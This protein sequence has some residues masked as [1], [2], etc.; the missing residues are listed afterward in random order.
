MDFYV[1]NS[2]VTFFTVGI[3]TVLFLAFFKRGL[4]EKF[5][6]L[7]TLGWAFTLLHYLSQVVAVL[8]PEQIN[9][10]FFLDRL[11]LSYSV[12]VFFLSAREFLGK[13]KSWSL[14][15]GL[16]GLFTLFS[17]LQ[18]YKPSDDPKNLLGPNWKATVWNVFQ[19]LNAERLSVLLGVVLLATGLLFFIHRKK[20]GS[21]GVTAMAYAF[22]VWGMAFL[23]F[24][25][26][27]RFDYIVPLVA[28]LINLPKP[29]VA[30][31][32]IIYL[33]ERE[34]GV[35]Q[36]HRDEAVQ[37]RDFIQSLMDSAYDSIY[38][39]DREGKFRW[40]NKAC[41]RLLGISSGELKTRRYSEFLE[42]EEHQRVSQAGRTVAS[43]NKASMEINVIT[44]GGRRRSMQIMMSPI[45][46]AQNLVSSVLTVGRDV[47]EVNAMERQLR[48]AEKLVALG[49][50]IAGVAH[51]LN[52]PLTTM[53]GFSELSLQEK[54]LDPRLRQRFEMILQAATRSKKI[55]ESLQ[56][57]VRVPEHHVEPVEIN[58]L[59][60]DNL[61]TMESELL[62]RKIALRL[63]YAPDPMWVD[64]DRGRVGQVIQSIV[65]N[66]VE[67]IRELKPE[68]TVTVT[69][70]VEGEQAVVSI[71]DDGTGIREPQRVF[72]P[73]YSTKEVGQG[74]G[75]SLSVGYSILQHYGGKILGENNPREGATFRILLPLSPSQAVMGVSRLNG[76]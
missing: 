12:L 14:L 43:G 65:K 34:E 31:A 10:A 5:F 17:F 9:F 38:L 37:Q 45:R 22:L 35:V 54:T 42:E 28:Q 41:E 25:F 7:W 56:N 76:R 60:A 50:M 16:G 66:A 20:F 48:H 62:A 18:I 19:L 49:R 64:V 70:G 32:M 8:S 67:A 24:P 55:V 44:P 52:N 53:M 74:T 47:T 26:V 30:V 6:Y 23:S 27:L 15:F 11:L 73:F 61:N 2:I 13:P 29:V 40:A 63:H 58:E 59:V 71:T 36:K 51:E 33:F 68:G 57:F 72:E 39:T 4:R 3:F 1:A 69:T 21:I 46:D 75:M